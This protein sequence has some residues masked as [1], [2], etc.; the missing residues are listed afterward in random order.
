[1]YDTRHL[2][3]DP[4]RDLSTSGSSAGS[5]GCGSA[6]WS[7]RSARWS[8]TGCA[9]GVTARRALGYQQVLAYLDG[10]HDRGRARGEHEAA[11]PG[12]SPGGSSS[13]FRRDPRIAWYATPEDL[14]LPRLLRTDD[15][16]AL[17]SATR[18]RGTRRYDIR[19]Q[20]CARR[21]TT[22]HTAVSGHQPPAGAGCGESVVRPTLDREPTRVGFRMST[23]RPARRVARA[24]VPLLLLATGALSALAS[25]SVQ[26]AKPATQNVIVSGADASAVRH[27]VESAGGT[28]TRDLPVIGGVAAR[29]AGERAGCAAPQRFRPCRHRR[30]EGPP[31]RHRPGARLRRRRRRG[32][33]VQHRQDHQRQERLDRTTAT[34]QG[35]RRRAH[36][37][38]RRAGAGPH[39]RQRRPRPD[40]SFESQTPTCAHLDT[41]GHGTHMAGIIAGRDVD[42]AGRDYAK[43]ARTSSSA[44]RRT[45]GSSASRSPR[46]TA[47]PTSSQVIA[48]DRLGGRSTRNDPGLNIRV[49]N[50]SLGTD[51]TQDAAVDPL[52]TPSRSPGAHGIVV[53]V[54][55]GNDGTSRGHADQPGDRPVR[56]RGRR[57][58]PE[59]HRRPSATTSS[60]AFSQR[61]SS[62]PPRRPDRARRARSLGLRDPGS[63]IDQAQPDG[64]SSARPVL[65][66]QRHLAGRRGVSGLRRA[67]PAAAPDAHRRTRSR[68][69]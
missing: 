14:V 17:A 12:G 24:A 13:W 26:A 18:Q 22:I 38:R 50:L 15:E 35:R 47:P 58:R 25:P 42:G 7:T 36:R 32:L 55:G 3:L 40:L 68:R 44:S 27:A 10:E 21:E 37:H 4:R 52:R 11:R 45:P 46:P 59:R 65:P 31:A 34:G 19:I 2:G 20:P 60:P 51:S 39:Q 69:R 62:T 53:V 30:R 6:G 54:A 23:T 61:G 33:A 5:T 56:H 66:R 8:A 41:F 48:G 28:V 1:M 64:R 9:T 29:D 49:L 67:A 63:H 57:R 16:V 43:P